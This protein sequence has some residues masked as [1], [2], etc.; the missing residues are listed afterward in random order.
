MIQF[1]IAYFNEHL[2]YNH[3]EECWAYYE[4]PGFNLEFLSDDEMGLAFSRLESFFW[5]INADFHLLSLPDYQSVEDIYRSFRESLSGPAV[6]AAK[7]H[8]DDSVRVLEGRYG[9]E[10]SNYKFFIGVKLPKVKTSTKNAWSEI[11]AYIKDFCRYVQEKFYGS[12]GLTNPQIYEDSVKRFKKSEKLTYNKVSARLKGQRISSEMMQ[13][14]I[15]RNWYRGIGKPSI[16]P[17]WAPA[18]S[19]DDHGTRYPLYYDILRLSEGKVDD[20]P[21]RSL[22]LS[23]SESDRQGHVAFLCVSNVPYDMFFPDHMWLY[24]LQSLDFPV[25][26]SIRVEIMENRRAIKEAR[27]KQKELKDQDRHSQEF[28]NDTSYTVLEGRHA[29]QEAEADLTSSRMPLLLT[30]IVFCVSAPDQEELE[31]RIDTLKNEYEDIGIHLEQ[32]LGDQWLL[33]NEFLPGAK[34]YVQDYIQIMEPGTLAGSMFGATMQL[35][36]GEGFYIGTTGNMEQPVYISPGKAAQSVRGVKTN[37][38]AAAFTGSTGKGKSQSAN[39]ILY[40][41]VLAGAKG[42]VIDPKGER[43]EWKEKLYGLQ[44]HTNI[45]NFSSEIEDAGALDPYFIF[46]KRRDAESVALNIL[47]F[48]TGVSINDSKRFPKLSRAVKEATSMKSIIDVLS[49]YRDPVSRA[50][51]EHIDSFKELSFAGLLFGDRPKENRFSFDAALTVL[52]IEGLELPDPETDPSQYTL[53]EKLSIGM[54]MPISSIA[55]KFIQEERDILKIILFDEAWATLNTQQGRALS[56]RLVRA[57]R[58]MNAS[59]FFVTQNPADLDSEKLKNNI[60]MKFVFG[61]TDT[62]EIKN[63]LKFLGLQDTKE[64]RDVIAGL[65]SGQCLMKDIYG[66]VGLL[67]FDAIFE[68][69]IEAFD[70]RPPVKKKVS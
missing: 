3:D 51:G 45:I 10:G 1:P 6:E 4:L 47:T 64:N 7:R 61:C 30:S 19:V 40:N 36:D 20:A 27:N 32:P 44:D 9:D 60:G 17:S 26:T 12:A 55:L 29:T 5:Q 18:C 15:R 43:G 56:S 46:D 67:E 34:R 59:V 48:L 58:A 25:E 23:Q 28:D 21:E 14:L 69:L 54:M 22:I 70:T 16:W 31:R 2:V 39:T 13:W 24:R 52:Q 42:L 41:T 49:S 37:S 33:F 38:L 68:D 66:R 35:G 65:E 63:A 50:L 11:D 62:D 8:V 57:G 53:S